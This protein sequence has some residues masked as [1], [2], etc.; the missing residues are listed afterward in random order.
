MYYA[1]YSE[2]TLVLDENGDETGD[3]GIGYG[4]P[5]EFRASLSSGNGTAHKEIWGTDVVITRTITTHDMSL[6]ISEDSLIWYESKPKV[7]ANGMADSKT[8]D[9]EVSAKPA[10]ALNSLVIP[11]K[12]RK[13]NA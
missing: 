3:D 9:Y 7:L 11:L 4:K 10:D 8:A 1:L 12:A 2:K 6:P 5:I 13:K